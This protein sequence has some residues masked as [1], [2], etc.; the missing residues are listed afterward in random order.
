[1][2]A[3]GV[4]M[5]GVGAWLMFEAWRN[6]APTPLVK[7]KTTLGLAAGVGLTAQPGTTIL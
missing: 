2:D 6:K 5:I 3:V 7:A 1:V 4:V